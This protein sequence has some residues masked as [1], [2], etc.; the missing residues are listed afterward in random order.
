MEPTLLLR[1]VRRSLRPSNDSEEAAAAADASIAVTAPVEERIKKGIAVAAAASTS[2]TRRKVLGSSPKAAS[3]AIRACFWSLRD[4]DRRASR[5]A[6]KQQRSSS[7]TTP[8]PDAA[9]MIA[10]PETPPAWP[11]EGLPLSGTGGVDA[12]GNTRAGTSY[13]TSMGVGASIP[14]PTSTKLRRGS[15]FTSATATPIK[16]ECRLPCGGSN[17]VVLPGKA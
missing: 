12:E 15:A 8:P 16:R 2:S 5:T 10:G 3:C 14:F 1:S 13:C 7:P 9:A 17:D 11:G 6:P 4:L